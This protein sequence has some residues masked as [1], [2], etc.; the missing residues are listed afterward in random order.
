[1]KISKGQ[2][3]KVLDG[4]K[5]PTPYFAKAAKDFDTVEDE[6]YDL[7]LDQKTP[8]RGIATVWYDGD[9]LPVRRGLNNI[10]PTDEVREYA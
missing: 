7:V 10:E 1:M 2:R 3:V 8:I 9:E 5:R 6:W 4:R